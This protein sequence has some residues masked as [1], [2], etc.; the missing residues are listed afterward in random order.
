MAAVTQVDCVLVSPPGEY[1]SDKGF[2][3]TAVEA[4]Q[5]IIILNEAPPNA[6]WEQVVGPATGT[7]ANGIALKDCNAGGTVEYAWW[8]EIDGYTGLTR[9]AGLTIVDGLVDT[10]APGAG[11]TR[12][13]VAVN[14]S[15]IRFFL[16]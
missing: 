1:G 16:V 15:R 10:T 13:I 7:T 8:G 12:Q 5:P 3:K 11:V 2:C 9:G 14:T 6:L 4:G